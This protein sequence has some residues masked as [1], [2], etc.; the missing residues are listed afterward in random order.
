MQFINDQKCTERGETFTQIDEVSICHTCYI[1]KNT[2]DT[3]K[4]FVLNFRGIDS[5]NRPVFERNKQFYGDTCNLF[6]YDAAVDDVL[7]FYKKIRI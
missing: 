2:I 5:W 7:G 6:A 3:S 1:K 4:D